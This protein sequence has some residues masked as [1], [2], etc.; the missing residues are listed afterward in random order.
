MKF[1]CEVCWDYD[2]NCTANDK[3][4]HNVR[5]LSAFRDRLSKIKNRDDNP[6]EYDFLSKRIKEYEKL[7]KE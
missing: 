1:A 5:S 3:H 7:I 2:C 6:V 4:N